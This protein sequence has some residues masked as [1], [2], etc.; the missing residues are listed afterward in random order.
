M[1]DSLAVGIGQARPDCFTVAKVGI[2]SDKWFKQYN[3]K[4][5]KQFKSV[6]IS[7]GTNDFVGIPEE[8]LYKIRTS[9]KANMV[10]WILP[11]YSLKP[12]QRALVQKISNEF[13]DKVLDITEHIGYDGIHPPSLI[14]YR[15]IADKTRKLGT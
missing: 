12:K 8:Y 2:T 13:G 3:P 7:L 4:L 11:S 15:K 9:I 10:V 6:I 5:D 14:E 1:G